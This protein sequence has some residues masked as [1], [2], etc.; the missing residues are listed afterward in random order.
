MTIHSKDSKIH[1][2]SKLD[3][4]QFYEKGSDETGNYMNKKRVIQIA[5]IVCAVL[6]LLLLFANL[7][8]IFGVEQ[9]QG[10]ST[11]RIL[12]YE[13]ALLMAL[14]FL[15]LLQSGVKV[16]VFR[17]RKKPSGISAEYLQAFIGEKVV[18]TTFI[19][20]F[21]GI[22]V[23]VEGDWLK[24]KDGDMRPTVHLLRSDMLLSLTVK[25]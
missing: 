4:L 10:F 25:K 19:E 17:H 15:G 7:F 22:L 21:N 13:S 8:K 3:S 12:I 14:L 1:I 20:V 9:A 23:E 2:Q 16:F 5:M 18:A 6:L 24:I 11:T